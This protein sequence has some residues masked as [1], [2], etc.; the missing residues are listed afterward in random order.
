MEGSILFLILFQVFLIALNAIFACREIAVLSINE[1]KLARMAE[2]GD[3]RAQKL[4]KL[5]RQPAKFLATIQVAITLS[6]FL[7]SAFAFEFND[8]TS[9]EIATHRTDVTI[10]WLEE[11]E[12]EWEDIIHSSRHTR[13]PVCDGSPD[14]IVGILNAKDY[15]RLKDKSR[16]SVMKNAVHPAYF[17]PKT[18]KADLLFRNMKNSHNSMAV[19]LDEYGGMMGIITFYDLIAELVGTLNDEPEDICDPQP[20]LEKTDNITWKIYG[21]VYLGDIEDE[22]G[23]ELK[24]DDFDTITGLVFN[25]MGEIPAD[26]EHDINVDVDGLK[27]HI[28]KVENHQIVRATIKIKADTVLQNKPAGD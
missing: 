3:K 6:G 9:G 15:F 5:T 4:Y 2:D 10:L 21:N 14:K 12:D 20:Y 16:E 28:T 23:I 8:I 27:V 13:Y 25:T 19:V 17:V 26:G 18:I 1:T 7:G 22:T 11:N 24:N